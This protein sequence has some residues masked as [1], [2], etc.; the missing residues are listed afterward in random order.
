[1]TTISS[2]P[3][4]RSYGYWWASYRRTWR[5]SAVS[6]L[7]SPV[8][9]L[10]AMGVGLGSLVKSGQGT[11]GLSYLQFVAPG[12]VAATAMQVGAAEAM[13]PVLAS[14][15]WVRN[16]HAMAATPL[17]P[18]DIFVGH[19]LW[20]ASRAAMA[21]TVY[22][23]IVAAFGGI[24]SAWAALALPTSVLVA[25]AFSAPVTA[26]AATRETDYGFAVLQRFVIIPMFLFSGT[27]FRVEQLPALVRP[28]AYALPLWHGVSL[29]RDL[30]TGRLESGGWLLV[31]AH[32][33]YLVAL[34]AAGIYFSLR[35][36]RRRL[37]V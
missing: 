23:G 24:R 13:Y 6:T 12:L 29:M 37:A 8:M 20:M 10:T 21:S 4:S 32:I 31:A 3:A 26:F 19:L 33:G 28:I 18:S 9:Y 7:V 16:Y 15:K 11:E 27:F 17:T 14:F 35:R 5:G 25:L 22:L 30:T 34:A 1:M 36:F 2:R